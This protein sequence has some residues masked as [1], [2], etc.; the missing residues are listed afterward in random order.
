MAFMKTATKSLGNLVKSTWLYFVVLGLI[1]VVLPLL[2]VLTTGSVGPHSYFL[3]NII[4]APIAFLI[5]GRF[6]GRK[7]FF[8]HCAILI[9]AAAFNYFSWPESATMNFQRE[10][11]FSN[12]SVVLAMYVLG[13]VASWLF[14]MKRGQEMT[15]S[16]DSV[17]DL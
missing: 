2:K 17:G 3:C 16:A 14:A 12:Y 5:L 1:V 4:L 15:L 7:E 11:A 10:L 9:A 13:L 8:F 6:H